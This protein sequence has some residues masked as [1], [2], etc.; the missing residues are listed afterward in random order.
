MVPQRTKTL[1]RRLKIRILSKI[2]KEKY[3]QNKLNQQE[4][5]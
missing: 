4:S 5:E 1:F 2:S 3:I